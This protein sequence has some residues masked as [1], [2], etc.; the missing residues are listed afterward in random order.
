M[1]ATTNPS[2]GT[3]TVR[4]EPEGHTIVQTMQVRVLQNCSPLALVGSAVVDCA[5]FER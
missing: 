4:L 5:D 3:I 2:K 1:N